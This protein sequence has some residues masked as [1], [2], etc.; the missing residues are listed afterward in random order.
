MAD[1]S[2]L[3]VDFGKEITPSLDQMQ[4]MKVSRKKL[5]KKIADKLKEKLDMSVS[6]FTQGS[7]AHRMRTI[8]IKEDGTY[9]ADRGIYLPEKP[10]VSAET[11]QRYVFE[12]VNDHTVDGAS[13]RKK[14]IRVY[15][16]RA[17][18]IDFP[19]YY[20][21]AGELYSYLAIKGNGWIKDDPWHMITWLEGYKDADGQLVRVIKY[22][23]A[24]ASKCNCKMPSGI[25]LAVWAARNFTPQKDRDDQCLLEL[26]KAIQT[27][28]YYSV[29]CIAPVEPYDDLTAKLSDDQKK[30]FKDELDDFVTE[31]Q[32]AVD[33]PNQ[34]KA[35]K[36]WRE[37][38][39]NR[40]PEGVDEDIDKR[41]NALFSS[42]ATVLSNT[43]K[44]DQ[45][46]RV[47]SATGVNHLKHRNYGS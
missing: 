27:V 28:V 8:I 33:E 6:F 36:I 14:C 26:L 9:D 2:K 22:L 47:N 15:F 44:L 20:E 11:V 19:V 45:Y 24:W 39:G 17:Y 40:F 25:A 12:A 18:N 16:Q 42:A 5:E 1:C 13:H 38:L 21:V 32:K 30:K 43:A 35:S 23:K 29:S 10:N 41:A 46:G 34:L 37:Y 7:R 31:G 3:F 4:K